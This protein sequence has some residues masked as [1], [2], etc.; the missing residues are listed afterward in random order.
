MPCNQHTV[1]KSYYFEGKGLHTGTYSHMKLMPAPA[2]HGIKFR[3][4]D[5]RSKPVIDALAENVTNTARSTTVSHNEAVAVTIEHIMSALTGLGVDNALIELDNIEVPILDGS[6]RP[7]VEAIL[8][9]GLKDQGVPREYIDIPQSLE[10]RD[11]RSGSWVRI[12][13]AAGPSADITVD[14]NSKILGIQSAHWDEHVDYAREIGV[15]R[16]FVFFHE[17]EYLFRNNLIKGGDV[18]NA[19]VIVEHPVNDEQLD[20]ISRLF[21]MPDLHITDEGYLNNLQ[22]HFPDECGRHKLLDLLGDMRLAGGYLNARITAY[23]PGHSINTKAAKALRA[24]LK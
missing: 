17:I 21:N 24:L 5:L 13:P 9:D 4:S 3:R 7:Y 23:K 20:A 14:F 15:C 6:A 1:K 10:I 22:L 12:E 11:D 16:T 19:I 18:D 2:G 8:Q